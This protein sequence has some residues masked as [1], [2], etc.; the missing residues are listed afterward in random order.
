MLSAP[1]PPDAAYAALQARDARFDGRLYVGVTSTGI[2]CRPICRVRLPRRENCRF[3]STAAQAEAECFRPCMKCRPE[4]APRALPWTTM[5]ASRTLASQAAAWLDACDDADASVEDLAKH[6]GITSR[7][8]RRIFQ[9]EHGVAPLQYLQTRRLLLAKALLTDSTLPVQEIAFAAGFASLRRFNAAF[10]EHYRLQPTALRREGGGRA[11]LSRLRLSYREP[12]DL[13]GVV[14]F[15]TPRAVAGVEVVGDG[16]ITRSLVLT[17]AGQ[18]HAGWLRVTF[19]KP[20]EVAVA[21]SPTLWPAAGSLLPRLRRWLDL[22]ADPLPI[23]AALGDGGV[24]G[25]RLPG[26]LDRFELAVRAVLGQ[27]VTVAA[28]RTLAGRFVE[29]FGETLP[30]APEGCTRLFPSPERIA[31]ATRDDIA[32]LGIIGRR[33]DSLV[34]LAQAWPTLAFARREGEP[35]A[36]AAQLCG[37]PGIGPWTASY[38]LMRGWSWPDAFPPGDVVLRK[39]LSAGGPLLPPKAYLAAAERYRPYRSYA[40]LHLWRHS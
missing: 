27:Q 25:Q 40:V 16:G 22:D 30:G 3:F 23:A 10:V 24:P 28:A 38:M 6:L 20:G 21:L 18:R 17:H 14:A 36:A 34:A 13:A 4:L 35:D 8:L 12:Y 39:A 31:M 2:Y 15:L 1:L 26:C 5:D 29:R 33:A 19:D 11:P 32:S 7:H 37:I 9:A